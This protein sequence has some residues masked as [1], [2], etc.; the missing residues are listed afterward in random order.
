[1]AGC[2]EYELSERFRNI[3]VGTIREFVRKAV[4]RGIISE[5]KSGVYIMRAPV[6]C[7]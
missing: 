3:S 7:S 5:E 1:M 6:R 2:D 4:T